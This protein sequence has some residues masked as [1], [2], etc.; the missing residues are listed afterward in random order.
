MTNEITNSTLT[1][2]LEN[3]LPTMEG[4]EGIKYMT[5]IFTNKLG[6]VLRMLSGGQDKGGVI[7]S[8]DVKIA[9]K[10]LNEA[11]MENLK[12]YVIFTPE[13]VKNEMVPYLDVLMDAII[14]LSSIKE[15][16]LKPLL[17]WVT[18]ILTDPTYAD[19]VW[20]NTNI[21]SVDIKKIIKPL[22]KQFDD[23]QGDDLDRK[24][25]LE[26]YPSTKEFSTTYKLLE[27]LNKISSKVMASN[28]DKETEKLG[29][30]FIKLRNEDMEN[31]FKNTHPK[32]IQLVSDK[33]FNTAKELELLSIMI[34]QVR[35]AT[36]A[37]NNTLQ[38]IYKEL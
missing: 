32:L 22:V 23:S 14:E 17:L 12:E 38:K 35:V 11:G 19:K 5:D 16:A 29:N 25:L 18:N 37:Y 10:K 34:F 3:T 9:L 15:R 4:L 7:V 30:M 2:H 36:T 1:Q 27:E 21:E 6:K 31:R 20:V 8:S 28:L 24:T 33:L 13:G 26:V